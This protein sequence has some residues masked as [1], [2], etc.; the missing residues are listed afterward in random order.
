MS[1]PT[2]LSD[3]TWMQAALAQARAAAI[4]GEVPVG[5]V[6][7]CDGKIIGL[8][9]NAPIQGH[10]P[11]AHAEIAALRA[12]AAHLGNYRLEDCELFVTLEP[13]LMCAG[14]MLHARLKRVVFGA[15]DP[16]TGAAGSVLNVF[17]EPQ[18]NHH[19][20]MRGGLLAAECSGVLQEFF[21][22][23]RAR[24]QLDRQ[25]QGR[26]LRE[27]A[28]RTPA[29]RFAAMAD[30]PTPAFY[31]N[32][33]TSL[34][35]WRLAYLDTGPFD[36]RQASLCLHGLDQWN[37]VWRSQV[38]RAISFG[39]RLICPDLIGF[40]QSDKPKKKDCHRLDWHARVLLELL[41]RLELRQ[42]RLQVVASALPL[43]RQLM[44]MAPERFKSMELTE[45]DTLDA[46]AQ[47]APFPDKG[48]RA[49][50][51]ALSGLKIDAL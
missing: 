9:R 41:D 46:R 28:L 40:G 26:A 19:T 30:L 34:A 21:Q 11:T 33:L 43:A 23:R 18:L 49:G 13:C 32:D 50:P 48:H 5:A 15:A 51:L 10:D 24:Q 45:V 4:A 1:T 22:A 29:S 16:K 14:A 38:A 31:V 44:A 20:T 36:C 39:Q 12:A 7:V 8:G 6:V 2:D 47:Q 42:V 3:A 27:D 37:Y 25:Q 17:A 35:G